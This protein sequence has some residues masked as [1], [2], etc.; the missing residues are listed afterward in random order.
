MGYR[1]SH[2]EVIMAL[3]W[4]FSERERC[5][6]ASLPLPP[7]DEK[8]ERLSA[9]LDDFREKT[10][11]LSDAVTMG[12]LIPMGE[13]D[14]YVNGVDR[15]FTLTA[16]E[17]QILHQLFVPEQVIRWAESKSYFSPEFPFTLGDIQKGEGKEIP[18]H[19]SKGLQTLIQASDRFWKNAIRGES[20]TQPA[21][22]NVSK[23]LQ[24]R[25]LPKRQAG[26]G[27]SVIRPEW[28][29]AGRKPEK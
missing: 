27:A 20:D 21:N 3:D 6:K 19:Y 12:I 23:W 8:I 14:K 10:H 13:A 17:H 11:Y 1:D 5:S 26:V 24:E 7:R 25:G 22:S 29:T 16:K 18:A 28:A 4:Y 15:F 9:S 2:V